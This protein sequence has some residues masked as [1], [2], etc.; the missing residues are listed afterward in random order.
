M[1]R[2]I[3]RKTYNT[4]ITVSNHAQAFDRE[5]CIFYSNPVRVC[6]NVMLS[7]LSDDELFELLQHSEVTTNLIL[8]EYRKRLAKGVQESGCDTGDVGINVESVT[9]ITANESH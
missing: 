8:G 4:V 3:L 6:F 5:G 1:K 9:D 2:D 7:T